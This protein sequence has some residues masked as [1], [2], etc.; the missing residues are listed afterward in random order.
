MSRLDDGRDEQIDEEDGE[1]SVSEWLPD[2]VAFV[3]TVT[4]PSV[5]ELAPAEVMPG[6]STRCCCCSGCR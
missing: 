1:S 4:V 5:D 3:V 6:A 2:V